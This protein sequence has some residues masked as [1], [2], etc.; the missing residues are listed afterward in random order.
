[1]T[2]LKVVMNEKGK[3]IQIHGHFVAVKWF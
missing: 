1:M 2:L 3:G